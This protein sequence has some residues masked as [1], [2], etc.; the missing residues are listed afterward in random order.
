MRYLIGE[1]LKD[2]LHP[3]WTNLEKTDVLLQ[4]Y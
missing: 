2:N 1:I 3:N 4:S